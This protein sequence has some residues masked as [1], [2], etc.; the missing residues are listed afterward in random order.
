MRPLRPPVLIIFFQLNRPCGGLSGDRTRVCRSRARSDVMAITKCA[1]CI[2]A[3]GSP[4]AALDGRGLATNLSRWRWLQSRASARGFDDSAQPCSLWHFAMKLVFAAPLSGLPFDP[5]AL[6][7]HISRLHLAR[8]AVRA[9]PSSS[10]PSF[11]IALFAHVPGACAPAEPIAKTVSK[12]AR[13]N[14]VIV[15]SGKTTPV[16]PAR[17]EAATAHSQSV[18]LGCGSMQSRSYAHCTR[19]ELRAAGPPRRP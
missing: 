6:G 1:I 9:A 11:P 8:K 15:S 18:C 16:T 10:R 7:S 4:T 14:R 3:A 2:R 13:A 17:E 19:Y 12:T 5:I